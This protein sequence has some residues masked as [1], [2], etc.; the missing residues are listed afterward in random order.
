MNSLRGAVV[1]VHV[2]TL[3]GCGGPTTPTDPGGQAPSISSIAPGTVST[4]GGTTVTIRGTGFGPGATVSIGGADIA[5]AGATATSITIVA[6]TRA[7]GVAPVVVSAGG[8]TASGTLTFVSP[9]GTN[10]PPVISSLRVAGPRPN[11]PPFFGDLGETLTVFATVSNAEAAALQYTWT[12][13]SGT[14]AGSGASVAWRLPEVLPVVPARVDI[15]LRIIETYVESG[16][17]HRNVATASAPVQVHHSQAEILD[18]GFRFL[19]RFSQSQYSV[20]DVLIDFSPT[21]DNGR[22]RRDEAE[23]VARNRAMFR[24]LP[25]YVITRVPPV[26]YNFGSACVWPAFGPPRVRPADGCATFDVRW[27]VEYLHDT[28]DEELGLIPRGSIEE[29]VGRDFVTAVL[30][31]DSWRLCHSDYRGTRTVTFPSGV[32]RFGVIVR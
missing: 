10:Q 25:G 13:G 27:R 1:A 14:I 26:T 28:S 16:V 15:S 2:L 7:A 19:D 30:E 22:G 9:S 23:D 6:P 17:E 21:C 5:P 31:N 32:K 24:Q 11:Q 29:S 18:K 3:V 20:N 4:T 8:R 12:A